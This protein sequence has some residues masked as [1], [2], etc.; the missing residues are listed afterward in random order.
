MPELVAREYHIL[1]LSESGEELVVAV[2]DPLDFD[3]FEKLRFF[4]N[5][6]VSI[7]HTGAEWIQRNIDHYYGQSDALSQ[8]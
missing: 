5:R 1:P 3:T 6:Q 2:S 7:V 4:L 8:K